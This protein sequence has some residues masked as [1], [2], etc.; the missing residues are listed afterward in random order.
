MNKNSV[1]GGK[2]SD[3]SYFYIVRGEKEFQMIK[4]K[5]KNKLISIND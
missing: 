5:H 1:L 3:N 4:N 2:F